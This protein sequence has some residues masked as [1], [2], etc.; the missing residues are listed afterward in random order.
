[1]KLLGLL[2]LVVLA[3]YALMAMQVSLAVL[4]PIAAVGYVLLIAN[5]RRHC[6]LIREGKHPRR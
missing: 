4:L 6:R 3:Y 5:G 2:I 1:M